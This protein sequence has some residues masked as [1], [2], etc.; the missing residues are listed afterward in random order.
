MISYNVYKLVHLISIFGLFLSLGCA[1]VMEKSQSRWT[2]PVHG[3]SLVLILV[4][5]FGM[6]ARLGIHGALPGWAIGKLAVWLVFGASIALAKR[7]VLP[8]GAFLSLIIAL[9]GLA[10]G[11]AL[12]KP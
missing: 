8:L 9:G 11:L 10:A 2:A 12:W 3:I 4:A 5:G 6:L 7:R 1:A